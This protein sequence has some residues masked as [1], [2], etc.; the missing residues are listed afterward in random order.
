MALALTSTAVAGAQGVPK[1]SYQVG[2]AVRNA[3]LTGFGAMVLAIPFG[4]GP[5]TA[6]VGAGAIALLLV[7]PGLP[8]APWVLIDTVA[9]PGDWW[10]VWVISTIAT[11]AT[12][13]GRPRPDLRG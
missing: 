6:V 1:P 2:A 5:A 8:P 9:D 12:V 7:S 13:S 4:R 10:A 3:A 11:L